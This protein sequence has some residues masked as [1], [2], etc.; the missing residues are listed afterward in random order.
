MRGPESL[1]GRF[2]SG[3]RDSLVAGGSETCVTEFSVRRFV[4]CRCP[5]VWY[6]RQYWLVDPVAV[7]AAG[8][9]SEA[10]VDAA[11]EVEEVIRSVEA[12]VAVSAAEDFPAV[13]E[14]LA[15]VE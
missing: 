1:E 7:T 2:F 15:A 5:S 8:I 12:A 6:R 14:A 10:A 3:A 13:A 9:P 11:S 4:W